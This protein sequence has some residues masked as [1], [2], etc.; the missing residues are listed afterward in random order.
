MQTVSKHPLSYY[1]YETAKVKILWRGKL[2]PL[3]IYK[4]AKEAVSKLEK[5]ETSK[6]LLNYSIATPDGNINFI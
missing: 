3:G 6:N 2:Q 1:S 5:I 4:T